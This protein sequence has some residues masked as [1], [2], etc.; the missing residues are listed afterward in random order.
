MNRNYCKNMPNLDLSIS[1]SE[2][3]EACKNP[4]IYSNSLSSTFKL[5][6]DDDKVAALSKYD[7]RF[8][9]KYPFVPELL[10]DPTKIHGEPYFQ[11]GSKYEVKSNGL[12]PSCQFEK[13][14]QCRTWKNQ[15]HELCTCM[16]SPNPCACPKDHNSSQITLV[17][18][19]SQ[20]PA[21]KNVYPVRS[22]LPSEIPFESVAFNH[23]DLNAHMKPQYSRKRMS[24]L[25]EICPVDHRSSFISQSS[26]DNNNTTDDDVLYEQSDDILPIKYEEDL[27]TNETFGKYH[28]VRCSSRGVDRSYAGLH[29]TSPYSTS[30]S[31]SPAQQGSP[32]NKLE[33]Y[34]KRI[35]KC[36]ILSERKI[37][38]EHPSNKIFSGKEAC[39]DRTGMSNNNKDSFIS[40]S[41]GARSKRLSILS[42]PMFS[43]SS[44]SRDGHG[45]PSD[46][47]SYDVEKVLI[48]RKKVFNNFLGCKNIA[49]KSP[50]FKSIFS[51]RLKSKWSKKT[52]AAS[53]EDLSNEDKQLVQKTKFLTMNSN[54]SVNSDNE[55][56]RNSLTSNGA[57]SLSLNNAK[58]RHTADN[59]P[60]NNPYPSIDEPC[61]SASHIA[62]SSRHVRDSLA[63]ARDSLAHAR[64]SCH[65]RD[66]LAPSCPASAPSQSSLVPLEGYPSRPITWMHV[67]VAGVPLAYKVNRSF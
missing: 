20:F 15:S 44:S 39:V 47:Q 4:R 61:G 36:K 41:T 57:Q 27:D 64:D 23:D 30:W 16:E 9:Y 42:A 26:N 46:L 45:T 22:E 53:M 28:F 10:E 34:L 8:E 32:R 21:F 60:V 2:D 37:H 52:K 50:M 13:K 63:R 1:D 12:P 58:S 38:I 25:F 66:A 6:H 17:G 56:Y 33:K 5:S 14:R 67:Y 24:R 18:H 7:S 55:I 29:P 40:D 35:A 59:N 3:D 43:A 65:S 51:K 19:Q 11:S 49:G 54:N 62:P 31:K 48:P